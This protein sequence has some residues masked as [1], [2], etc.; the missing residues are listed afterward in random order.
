MERV[1]VYREMDKQDSRWIRGPVGGQKAAEQIVGE[2]KMLDEL[3]SGPGA[4][5]NISPI[6]S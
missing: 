6:G 4:R 1:D 3:C 5:A 2:P